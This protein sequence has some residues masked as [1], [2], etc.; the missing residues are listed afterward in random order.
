M[1]YPDDFRGKGDGNHSESDV[2]L[3]EFA[4]EERLY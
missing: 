2:N 1:L 4:F 3:L